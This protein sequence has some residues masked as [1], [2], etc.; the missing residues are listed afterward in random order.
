MRSDHRSRESAR[1]MLD[2][3]PE[4]DLRARLRDALEGAERIRNIVLDVKTFSRASDDH[5]ALV[6]VRG[7]I[8]A[9][10]RVVQAEIRHKATVV[11]DYDPAPLVMANSGQLGQVIVNLL[12]NA[13]DAVGDGAP[14]ENVI[15]ITT[16][17]SPSQQ[18]V[19]TVSDSGGGIPPEVQH[20]IFDP[21]FTTRPVGVGTGMGL[22]ICH[23]IVRSLGGEIS[24]ESTMG[25]GTTFRIALPS[26]AVTKQ[27]SRPARASVPAR[28]D[29]RARVLIIDD[30]PQ[31]IHVLQL[32]LQPDHDTSS[33]ASSVEALALLTADTGGVQF[34]AVLC[35]LHMPGTSGMDLY[36]KL[37]ALRPDVAARMVFMT[38]GTFTARSRE[39]VGRVANPCIDKPIDI[40]KIRAIIATLAR[41]PG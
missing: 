22:S 3:G 41:K 13:A 26:A 8:D 28:A 19:I 36:E 16:G 9:A 37:L 4:L 31:L 24:V 2:D 23:G 11:K 40:K 12:L 18:A 17:T 25:K 10:I 39:F 34:D 21:F 33:V 29:A 27:S 32:L 35:D 20:R 1:A 7:V 30:E 6:D 38:G 14:E 5:R 15:R